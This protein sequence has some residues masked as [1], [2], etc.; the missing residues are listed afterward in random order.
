MNSGSVNDSIV[1]LM[2]RRTRERQQRRSDI[3]QAAERVFAAKGF[4]AASIEEIAHAAEFASGTVYLYFKDKEALY[5]ELF[6]EKIRDLTSDIRRQVEKINDP[7]EALKTLVAVRMGY[8][9]HNRTF[10]R[11]YAREGINRY[12]GREGRWKSVI[13]LYEEYL[14]LIARLVQAGQRR[15]VIRKGDP[16]LFAV[17]LSGMMIHLT[18]DWLQNQDETM[19]ARRAQFVIEL[20]LVGAGA[21]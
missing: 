21:K 1:R 16:R 4:H 10:F 20:F 12:E 15:G 2:P 13:Q 5:I 19:L 8:F 17:A 3:L 9:E 6:E 7:V 11:I 18:R 14:A